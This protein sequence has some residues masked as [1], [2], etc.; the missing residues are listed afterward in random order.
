MNE[1][2][3][4][5][6]VYLS[7]VLIT[8]ILIFNFNSIS[9]TSTQTNN[10]NNGSATGWNGNVYTEKFSGLPAGGK[11]SQLSLNVSASAGHVRAKIYDDNGIVAVHSQTH[12]HTGSQIVSGG[13]GLY[14]QKFSGLPI[15]AKI[16][17]L[18]QMSYTGGFTNGRPKIFDNTGTLVYI[19]TTAHVNNGFHITSGG[20]G[21]WLQEFTGLPVGKSIT[22]FG[23]LSQGGGSFA[24]CCT[25][26]KIYSD[27]GT[28]PVNLLGESNPFVGTLQD[29]NI[30]ISNVPVPANG[31]VYAGFEG[32]Y[33]T[34]YQGLAYTAA[35]GTCS[36]G[37][38]FGA[39]PSVAGACGNTGLNINTVLYYNGANATFAGN[40][41]GESLVNA[42][43]GSAHAYTDLP[44]N[45]TVPNDG[46]VWAGSEWSST[47]NL[48]Y[49]NANNVQFTVSHVFGSG[50]STVS[51]PATSDQD[52]GFAYSFKLDYSPTSGAGTL[53]GQSNSITVNS[54]GQIG[55]AHV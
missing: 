7:V 5:K 2:I 36:I 54:T 1:K 31:K 14:V 27:N 23:A 24:N 53:L 20:G 25:R 48:E 18:E 52:S 32:N 4:L 49:A 51:Q 13:N 8:L 10:Y 34:A 45:A 55:R 50:P 37:H 44:V 11:I 33:S 22:G 30:L 3:D 47:T 17:G 19:N 26:I 39:G 38:V 15:G 42:P 43:S 46:T 41:I 35:T 40:L 28:A 6:L 16:T 21:I 12:S 29:Y 9:A